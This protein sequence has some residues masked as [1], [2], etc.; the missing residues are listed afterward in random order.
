MAAF[1]TAPPDLKP[2]DTD[3]WPAFRERYA[4]S[5]GPFLDQLRRQAAGA[6]EIEAL[7]A[8]GRA[9]KLRVDPS[10]GEVAPQPR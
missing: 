8:Q 3:G 10:T 7:A 9:A 1:E 4:D 5:F 6:W 2:I